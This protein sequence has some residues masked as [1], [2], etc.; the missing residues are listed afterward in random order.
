M[1]D[2]RYTETDSAV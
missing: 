1:N 2:E